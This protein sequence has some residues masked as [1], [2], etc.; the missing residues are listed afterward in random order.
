MLWIEE[1]GRLHTVHGIAKE[2]DMTWQLNHHHQ[3]IANHRLS[4]GKVN[5]FF[6]KFFV[7]KVNNLSVENTMSLY[8]KMQ[9][10]VYD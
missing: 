1:S 8:E 4:E 3:S 6:F 7:R 5:N 10:V 9:V 2:L